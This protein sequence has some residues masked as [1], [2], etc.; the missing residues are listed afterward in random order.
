M[1][2][3][4][5]AKPTTTTTYVVNRTNGSCTSGN[6]SATVT[7]FNPIVI[8]TQPASQTVCNG[9]N[10]TI[11]V[12]N[13]GN[14]PAYQWELSTDNGAT[15]NPIAGANNNTITISNATTAITGRRYR[16]RITNTCSSAVSNAAILTVNPM[17]VVAATDLF[18]QRV[19]LSDTLVPL[20]GTPSGG[21]WSGIGVSGFN[22]VP[23]ATAVGSYVLTYSYTNNFGC[24]ATDTTRITVQDCPER[25]R[26]LRDDAVILFPNPNSGN[27]FIRMNSTLYNYLGM[28]VYSSSGQLVTKKQF[29][30]LVY[31]RVIPVNLT[32]LPN[33][34]YMIKFFYDDGARTSEN[35]F[36]V[37][38]GRQ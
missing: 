14:A 32:H 15:W 22:F 25:I 3:T 21:S 34:V 6:A 18:N 1:A 5:Y 20:A 2:A 9:A 29:H 16:V 11:S 17:P 37:I 28:D 8:T 35:T 31:G 38:I 13:T 26:L 10:V 33:G 23:S 12:A 4:V 24:T 27:F 30:G 36:K 7:V 19:C